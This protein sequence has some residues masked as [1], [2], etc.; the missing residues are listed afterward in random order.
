MDRPVISFLSDFGPESAPAICRG[1]IL[2]IARDAQIIDI[3]HS[4]PKFAI[5]DGAYLLW[6]AVPWL[7]VG[8][9]LAVVDP[10]VGSDR[11]PVGIRAARGDILVGPDNGLLMPA[12]AVLGG[13]VEA[14]VL[15]NREL[16]LPRT[17]AT[18][19]GRD[20]FAPVAA[21]LATGRAFD[22]VGPPISPESLVQLRFPPPAISGAGLEATVAFVDSF[23]NLRL[24]ATPADLTA[25]LGELAP[26]STITV[27]LPG[28]ADQTSV[29]P[30][31]LARTFADRPVGAL[32]VYTDSS[33]MLAISVNQGSAARRTGA[34]T[35]RLVRLHSARP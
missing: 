10:G 13:A 30:A 15:Q 24:F 20:V 29:E 17:G 11:L 23:G 27:E 26:G 22:E 28:D 19:H 4:V 6:S 7:P 3:S 33:G 2:S 31:T 25:A 16:L 14:R 18:F 1:V 5:L 8:V 21:H 9:H 12:A 35:G 32:L 34:V